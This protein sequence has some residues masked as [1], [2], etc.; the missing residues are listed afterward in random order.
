MW[1][2][3][4]PRRHVRPMRVSRLGGRVLLT[5]Y[6]GFSGCLGQFTSWHVL[7][8]PPTRQSPTLLHNIAAPDATFSPARAPLHKSPLRRVLHKPTKA[9][10]VSWARASTPGWFH[11]RRHVVVGSS[12]AAMRTLLDVPDAKRCELL[13]ARFAPPDYIL[14]DR[15]RCLET[16]SRVE[17]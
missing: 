17:G 2:T 11:A 1:R 9:G 4:C 10:I 16:P 7:I 8:V 3:C 13:L 5:F 6:V 14:V 15:S 12:D